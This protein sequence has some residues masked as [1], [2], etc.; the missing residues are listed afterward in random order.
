MANSGQA[1]SVLVTLSNDLITLKRLFSIKPS[2]SSSSGTF[3]NPVRSIRTA[4]LMYNLRRRH[5]A[6]WEQRNSSLRLVIFI[7]S[8]PRCSGEGGGDDISAQLASLASQLREDHQVQVDV[9]VFGQAAEVNIASSLLQPFVEAL[10]E[11]SQ[12]LRITADQGNQDH[13]NFLRTVFSSLRS[14]SE[15]RLENFDLRMAIELSLAEKTRAEQQQQK[16]VKTAGKV[17]SPLTKK[18]EPA[19]NSMFTR[20]KMTIKSSS[21]T[22]KS[23]HTPSAIVKDKSPK[24]TPTEVYKSFAFQASKVEK[25]KQK[26]R[27]VRISFVSYVARLNQESFKNKEP[28]KGKL[29]IKLAPTTTTSPVISKSRRAKRGGHPSSTSPQQYKQNSWM[30]R[31]PNQYPKAGYSSNISPSSSSPKSIKKLPLK[32]GKSAQIKKLNSA[33]LDSQN[34]EKTGKSAEATHHRKTDKSSKSGKKR[35]AQ[36]LI[37]P[38]EK[39]VKSSK[40][41][42]KKEASKFHLPPPAPP[43]KTTEAKK[44]EDSNKGRRQTLSEKKSQK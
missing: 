13:H 40:S 19:N 16:T 25:L 18:S 24:E 26:F 9:I 1:N 20:S 2:S 23:E 38:P 8:I 10:G 35:A 7:C 3:A 42:K 43:L 34:T 6:P 33:K 28:G 39:T 32:S 4:R 15:H 22:A 5:Q 41:G 36:L 11:G 29:K 21:P 27:K 30:F 17:R 12:L 14:L 44:K 37:H 31:S